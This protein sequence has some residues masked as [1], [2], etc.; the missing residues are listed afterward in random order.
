MDY[1]YIHIYLIPVVLIAEA[2]N[3]RG[4]KRTSVLWLVVATALLFSV[5][6]T[7][8]G[9]EGTHPMESILLLSILPVF[10]AMLPTMIS[11]SRKRIW[12]ILISVPLMYYVGNIIGIWIWLGLGYGL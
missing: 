7:V 12:V 4:W 11:W 10:L 5:A 6:R 2:L 3:T 9:G 8:L 1:D